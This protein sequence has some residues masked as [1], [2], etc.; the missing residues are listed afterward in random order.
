MF[1]SL[2]SSEENIAVSVS[3]YQDVNFSRETQYETAVG[4]FIQE[5]TE[6]NRLDDAADASHYVNI[7]VPV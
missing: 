4:I 1:Y 2:C 5:S 6:R 3:L 7:S